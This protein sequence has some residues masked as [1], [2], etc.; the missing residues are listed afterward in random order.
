MHYPVIHKIQE[1][2]INQSKGNAINK[3]CN[4]IIKQGPVFGMNFEAMLREQLNKSQGLQ[5][6][7]HAKERTEQ[8]GIQVTSEVMNTLNDAVV[9]ARKKGAKD[10]LIIKQEDVFIINVPSNVVVTAMS[11]EESKKNV[12]TNI[13]SAVIL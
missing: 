7:K 11:A 1:Y 13:D 12:Y 3:N 2:Q 5:L 10:I 6:S 8:R 9:S 4:G